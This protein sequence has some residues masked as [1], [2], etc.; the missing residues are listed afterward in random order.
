MTSAGLT[1]PPL[2][3]Y[4]AEIVAGKLSENFATPWTLCIN[5]ILSLATRPAPPHG[6]SLLILLM[7]RLGLG[8]RLLL[9]LL[10]LLLRTRATVALLTGS[11]L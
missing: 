9:L 6:Y 2:N 3:Q 4:L 11:I 1:L 7:L 8:L 5:I 10:L